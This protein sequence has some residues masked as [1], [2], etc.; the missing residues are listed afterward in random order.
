MSAQGLRGIRTQ[1]PQI[2]EGEAQWFQAI[3]SGAFEFP[4]SALETKQ[5]GL[6]P[7]GDSISNCFI[8]EGSVQDF[9]W[10]CC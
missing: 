2:L 3:L 5:R 4:L 10:F 1:S 8:Y 6:E 7:Q 9:M